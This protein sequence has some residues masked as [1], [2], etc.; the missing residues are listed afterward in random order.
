M[1]HECSTAQQRAGV[2]E[3]TA[4]VRH[5]VGEHLLIVVEDCDVPAAG[6]LDGSV[7]RMDSV[8]GV[9]PLAANA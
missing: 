9:Q 7:E 5:P 2:R 6:Q 3:S 8:V 1:L 4:E